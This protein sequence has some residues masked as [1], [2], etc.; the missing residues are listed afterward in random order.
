[1]PGEGVSR[2]GP[3]WGF[4]S[5]CP[6]IRLQELPCVFVQERPAGM[7]VGGLGGP[8]GHMA[9]VTQPAQMGEQGGPIISEILG[10]CDPEP[11]QS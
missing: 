5:S 7:E 3:H 6:P 1:M 11:G 9:E 10:S 8:K 4:T 2:G